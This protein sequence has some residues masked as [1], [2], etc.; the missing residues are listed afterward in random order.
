M[1]KE[2]FTCSKAAIAFAAGAI[3]NGVNNGAS[4]DTMGFNSFTLPLDI[5]ITA[6]QID[7]IKFEQSDDAA[8]SPDPW[9]PTSEDTDLFYPGDFPLTTTGGLII[10]VGSVAKK[11]YIRV[12]IVASD[13]PT[14]ALTS[15]IGLL[16]DSIR[17]PH[18]KESSVIAD[19]DIHTQGDTAGTKVT[20]PK[21]AV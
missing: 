1:N 10:N 4:I 19:D 11:R 20:Y 7:S 2:Q 6:G 17:K 9:A 14:I 15:A 21:R 13:T 3:S 8:G 5:D 16:Q 18:S 12:V